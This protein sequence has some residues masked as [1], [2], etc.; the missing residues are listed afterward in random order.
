VT[1]RALERA[2]KPGTCAGLTISCKPELTLLPFA[3]AGVAW[4]LSSLSRRQCRWR[5]AWLFVI[6]AV[7]IA[8]LNY[9][10]L[11]VSVPWRLLI[12]DTYNAFSQPQNG[13]LRPRP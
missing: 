5:E 8:V 3:P 13:A 12:A 2:L 9:V 11:V 6:P 7:G 1:K 4:A 10:P